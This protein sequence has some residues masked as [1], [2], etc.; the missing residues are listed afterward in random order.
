MLPKDNTWRLVNASMVGGIM[1]SM[2]VT[3]KSSRVNATSAP[4]S[5]EIE[6]E[7]FVLKKLNSWRLTSFARSSP[8]RVPEDVDVCTKGKEYVRND[9]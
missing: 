5:S 4:S 8:G 1:P 7:S 2:L 9:P 3:L 6:P